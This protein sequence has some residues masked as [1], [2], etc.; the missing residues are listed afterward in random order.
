MVE[1]SVVTKKNEKKSTILWEYG[2]FNVRKKQD[3]KY[4]KL[5][6]RAQKRAFSIFRAFTKPSEQLIENEKGN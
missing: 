5:N 1:E 2:K 4:D 3:E 6:L